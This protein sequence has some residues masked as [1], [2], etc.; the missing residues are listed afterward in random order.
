MRKQTNLFMRWVCLF[1]FNAITKESYMKTIPSGKKIIVLSISM[2]TVMI[3]IW[4]V[5]SVSYSGWDA[6][7]VTVN[8]E[9]VTQR[10]F[11][12]V[13]S[14]QRSDVYSYFQRKYG[15]SDNKDFWTHNYEGE[16]PIEVARKRALDTIVR[17]KVEQLLAREKG[18]MD[19]IHDAHF[20]KKLKNENKRRQEAVANNQVIYG[21]TTYSESGYF[22]YIHSNMVLKV[23]Q[24]M[25]EENISM[26]TLRH[27]YEDRK[28]TYRLEDQIT[29][30]KITISLLDEAGHYDQK[31]KEKSKEQ[32]KMMKDQ[33]PH[34]VY[35]DDLINKYKHSDHLDMTYEE[36]TFDKN[37]PNLQERVDHVYDISKTLTIGQ[38]SPIIE[39]K[40][41]VAIIKVVAIEPQGYR[42]LDEVMYHV[43]SSYIDETYQQLIDQ[44]VK[45]ADVRIHENMYHNIKLR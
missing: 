2:F 43:Q 45:E 21:P 33:W 37:D 14:K 38:V 23:K 42:P 10:E 31:I 13:L 16:V 7:L 1:D 24:L 19:N 30:H 44:L 41:S 40:D 39:D 27:F 6:T 5:N 20:L 34:G 26:E 29:I 17:I 11:K 25:M 9:P 28:E 32:L 36:V 18:V 15:A 3:L 8:H 4:R 35:Y 12:Q 22:Q